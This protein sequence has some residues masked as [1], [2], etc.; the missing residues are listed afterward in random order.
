MSMMPELTAMQFP[1]AIA[2]KPARPPRAPLSKPA[3]IVEQEAKITV[4]LRSPDTEHRELRLALINTCA[5]RHKQMNLDPYDKINDVFV[6]FPY[7]AE[8]VCV[9]AFLIS[10][11][12]SN[13]R[14]FY[15]RYGSKGKRECAW[16]V[17]EPSQRQMLW[18][19]V[20]TGSLQRLTLLRPQRRALCPA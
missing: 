11:Y 19:F 12:I 16:Q 7:L 1:Q 9:R 14:C 18:R 13:A 5:F 15:C 6:D 3:E 20:S 10:G 8:P 2:T 4:E 17:T